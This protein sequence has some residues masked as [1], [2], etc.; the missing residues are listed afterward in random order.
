M[1]VLVVG[2]T[3]TI[4]LAVVQALSPH[5]RVVTA[6]YAKA[7]WK[8]DLA[9]PDSIEALFRSVGRLDAVVSAAGRAAFGPLLA[10]KDEDFDLCLQNKLMGQVNLVRLGIP[11][12]NDNGSF[13][14]TS[15][16][17]AREPMPGSAAIS[18]VNSG[19][20]AFAL[21]ASLELPRGLR[22]NVISPPWVSETLKAMGRDPSHGM[23]AADVAKAYVESV[24]GKDNGRVI[25]ARSFAPR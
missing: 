19:L 17:L 10:L 15:G 22:I 24:E 8:V 3:G 7:D 20:E 2:G 1:R 18:L 11:H 13:T 14:L 23:P 21:A 12:V 6:S 5:H 4:G 25:D 16:V 9:S